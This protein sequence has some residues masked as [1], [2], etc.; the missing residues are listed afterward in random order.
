[1][2]TKICLNFKV[3]TIDRVYASK[4]YENFRSNTHV[5]PSYTGHRHAYPFIIWAYDVTLRV[6]TCP[7]DKFRIF[8]VNLKIFAFALFALRLSYLAEMLIAPFGESL[9]LD[10]IAF[11]LKYSSSFMKIL[12]FKNNSNIWQARKILKKILEENFGRKFR[13]RVGTSRQGA[14]Y[15]TATE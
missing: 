1:M 5:N 3:F 9:F 12:N 2:H 15:W 14:N 4:L 6:R 13:K 8:F 11:I 10:S 7:G